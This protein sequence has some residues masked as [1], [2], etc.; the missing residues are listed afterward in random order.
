MSFYIIY[1]SLSLYALMNKK[2]YIHIFFLVSLMRDYEEIIYIIKFKG[3][4]KIKLT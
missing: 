3:K 4:F 2:Y 1:F